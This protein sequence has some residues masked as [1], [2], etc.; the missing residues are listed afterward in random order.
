MR[1]QTSRYKQSKIVDIS[2][3]LKLTYGKPLNFVL[4]TDIST[5]SSTRVVFES[6]GIS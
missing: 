2:T 6:L 3:A 5:R 4:T 1:M